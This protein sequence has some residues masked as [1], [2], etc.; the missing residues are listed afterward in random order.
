MGANVSTTQKNKL[1]VSS[2]IQLDTIYENGLFSFGTC[3]CR[4]EEYRETS[5]LQ[6]QKASPVNLPD[7]IGTSNTLKALASCDF[8]YEKLLKQ[9]S[10]RKLNYENH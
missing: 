8:N 7:I 5:L 3:L 2:L 6:Y 4:Q 10:S 1:D 9:A